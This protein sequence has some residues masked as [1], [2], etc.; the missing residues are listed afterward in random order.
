MHLNSVRDLKLAT[1]EKL[2]LGSPVLEDFKTVGTFDHSKK[3]LR[4]CSETLKRIHINGYTHVV[5]D[6]P[7][8]QCLRVMVYLP[9]DLKI[10]NLGSSTKLDINIHYGN[11]VYDRSFICDFL[12]IVSRFRD[13]VISDVDWKGLIRYSEPGP[14]LQLQN[15]FRLNVKFSNYDLEMLPTILE[16]CPKLES[17][18]LE[19]VGHNKNT[20]LKVA[21]PRVPACLGS[22]LK[23]VDFKR[24][25]KGF[26]GEME[27][28]RYFLKNSAILDMLRLD[29]YHT[30]KAKCAFFQ[31]LVAMP[32]CSSACKVIVL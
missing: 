8:L 9:K 11:N 12:T 21:F 30:K 32:R 24:S 29:L 4:V 15:I 16:S 20:E 6:A 27:L 17:L 19:L 28:V 26:E 3:F 2:I 14:L 22:S 10:I 7:L 1:V 5:I 18:I 23:F 31:E 25:S 13:V